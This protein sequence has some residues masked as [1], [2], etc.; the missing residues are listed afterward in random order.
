MS[1][2][3]RSTWNNNNCLC[4]IQLC[5]LFRQLISEVEFKP[6]VSI[7]LQNISWKSLVYF[8]VKSWS[9]QRHLLKMCLALLRPETSW[10]PSQ[11]F[12][13]GTYHSCAVSTPFFP[14]EEHS[15][16][17][18]ELCVLLT[19]DGSRS[20]QGSNLTARILP[21]P[22]NTRKDILKEFLW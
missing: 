17:S 14:A 21:K 1:L 20:P 5:D 18:P 8:R 12:P 9:K 6:D 4:N 22:S 10:K 11:T 2:M 13:F 3:L 16:P 7:T 15:R 19:W